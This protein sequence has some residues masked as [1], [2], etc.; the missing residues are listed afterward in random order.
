LLGILLMGAPVVT[1]DGKPMEVDTR[2]ATAILAYIAV[3]GTTSRDFLTAMLW[4]DAPADRARSAL[5]R[6]LSALRLGTGQEYVTADRAQVALTGPVELD[7]HEFQAAVAATHEHGHGPGDVCQRCVPSL[8]KATTLYRGDFLQGFSVRDAPQFEDW[9]RA[10]TEQIRLEV[11]DAFNRLAHG[12]A[13]AGDYPAAIGTVRRWVE[14]DPLHEP[15]HRLQMLL[16][17]WAGDR[18]GAVSAYRD[19]V[20]ILDR[21]LGVPPLEETTELFEAILDED[22]PPAPG[23]RRRPRVGTASAPSPAP[24]PLQRAAEKE[25][26]VRA[27]ED[28]GERGRVVAVTGGSWMG[29]TRF[30]DELFAEV[31]D[32]GGVVFQAGASRSEKSLPYGVA[33]QLVAPLVAR[34]GQSSE[35]PGWVLSEL[36]RIDPRIAPSTE[37]GSDRF[38]QLRLFEAF[39]ELLA[40]TS[41]EQQVLVTVDDMQWSDLPSAHLLSFL[42]RRME[43]VSA[44]VVLAVDSGEFLDEPVSQLLSE[45]TT[46][47]LEPIG[48]EQ[49]TDRTVDGASAEAIVANTG[50][51]PLLVLEALETDSAPG[52]ELTRYLDERL[53]GI[54]DLA[55]Q[56]LAA[57]AV[58]SS[59]AD[60]GLLREVSGR[61][62]LEVVEGLE[63]LTNAGL[64]VELPGTMGYGFTLDAMS[65]RIY[66]STSLAR[67]RLLHRRAGDAL[68]AGPWASSDPRIAASIAAHY[69]GAGSPLAAAWF[70]RAGDLSG[71]VYAHNEA[72]GFYRDAIA[73]SGDE[74]GELHLLVAEAALAQGDY[75]TAKRELDLASLRAE[76]ATLGLVEHRSG[77]VHRLLGRFDLASECFARSLPS[78]PQPATLLADWALL[79]HRQGEVAEAREKARQSLELA[80][81]AG[82][83]ALARSL[84][85]A[86]TVASDPMEAIRALDQALELAGENEVVRMT[87]LN[88]KAHWLTAK[89][90]QQG[91]VALLEEAID[92]AARTGHRHREAALRNHLADVHH[93]MGNDAGARRE[94]EQ[95]VTLFADVAAGTWEPELWLLRHW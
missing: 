78:H 69:Q 50:G 46:V 57:A 72:I 44:L 48:A 26:V 63:E 10:T 45:I 38:G 18:P 76:G 61:S 49:L 80:P 19:F 33:G 58:A 70:R 15:A 7:V 67:R 1:V 53:T 93:E 52:H 16:H 92:L 39:H 79:H 30:L 29:K 68:S 31:V 95:A 35:L 24:T 28:T 55:R 66:E 86:A 40:L 83:R 60:F 5:R 59:H 54:S 74:S 56:I 20:G 87:A 23:V 14:L 71:Q 22:L 82:R 43:G 88:N 4:S 42:S 8:V 6:T 94:L 51:V 9:M 25:V 77:E 89:G 27:W 34:A 62:E 32:R 11:G 36:A 73:V 2:K 75:S 13:A 12:Q 81:G 3:E 21:E 91:A 90:D 84:N 64:L 85:V 47:A 65:T 41:T 37:S 17:A